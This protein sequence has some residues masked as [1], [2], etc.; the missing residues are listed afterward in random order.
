MK[1]Y[2]I[3]DPKYFSNNPL[4]LEEK[5][6]TIL[7]N[8]KVDYACFRDKESE[9]FEELATSFVLTCKN[10]GIE[11]VLINGN[12]ELAKKLNSGVHLTSTQFDLIKSAKH[13]NLFTIISCHNEE[14]IKKAIQ[15]N[16]DA[17]TYSPIFETPNKGEPK[18]VE[19]LNEICSKYSI[20]IFALGGIINNSQ[21]EEI[22]KTTAYG[23]ASI[24]YFI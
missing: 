17:I 8:H 22:K 16:A 14:D 1:Q 15:S 20:K 18:G 2:L 10:L 24:R 19:K 11:N 4:N 9:N 23:F 13:S 21:V 7:K 5:I 6:S 3:T 12:L